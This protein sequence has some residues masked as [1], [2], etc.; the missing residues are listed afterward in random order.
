MLFL[1]HGHEFFLAKY[2]ELEIQVSVV[3][4]TLLPS[5]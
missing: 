3:S 1:V 2:E 4:E 5:K